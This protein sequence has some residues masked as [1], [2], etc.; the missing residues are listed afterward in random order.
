MYDKELYE[1]SFLKTWYEPED[2]TWKDCT[3]E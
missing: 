3:T 2:R 1:K